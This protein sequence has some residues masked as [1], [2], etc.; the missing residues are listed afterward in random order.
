MDI[1]DLEF[2]RR[3]LRASHHRVLWR[4][5]LMFGCRHESRSTLSRASSAEYSMRS[6]LHSSHHNLLR[7]SAGRSID[8]QCR[9][10][11]HCISS[12]DCSTRST[13]PYRYRHPYTCTLQQYSDTAHWTYTYRHSATSCSYSTN[14][15]NCRQ[16]QDMAVGPDPQFHRR[17]SN[18]FQQLSW[19]SRE[20]RQALLF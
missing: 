9:T 15:A 5:S 7:M 3:L 1:I 11:S 20:W 19:L 6:R 18:L 13:S 17:E 4:S 10:Y 12:A 14:P 2:L 8:L 16:L